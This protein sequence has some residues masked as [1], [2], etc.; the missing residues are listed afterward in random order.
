MVFKRE[1][2]RAQKALWIWV[3]ALGGMSF[4][5]MSIYPQFAENKD[6][7][8][9]LMKLY[10]EAMLKA[11]N[12]DQLGFDSALGFYA[13][14]GYLFVTLFGSIYAA[15]LAGGILVKEESDRTIEFLLAKPI[16]RTQVVIQKAAA[17]ALVLFV[18]NIVLTIINYIG[19]GIAD[20]NQVDLKTFFMISLAPFLLHLTFA[21]LSFGISAFFRKQRLVTSISLAIVLFSYFMSIVSS[22]S[23]KLAGLKW[24][25]PFEYVSSGYIIE[26]VAIKPAYLIIMVLVIVCSVA[27][28]IWKY[29]KK[30]LIV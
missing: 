4:L 15:L 28:A 25:T 3:I 6:Q 10:P 17:V 23:D 26:H 1:W 20:A 18:F 2:K 27:I 16:S 7:L 21:A 13:I 8:Q 22:I 30:D 5:I 11:F 12:I 14:E 24:I 19:F 29:H 9:E